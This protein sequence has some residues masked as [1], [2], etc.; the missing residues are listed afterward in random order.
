MAHKLFLVLVW[1]LHTPEHSELGV[2]ERDE[3]GKE[4]EILYHTKG[5]AL[6]LDHT[7]A[8]PSLQDIVTMDRR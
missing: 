2:F 1:E 6:G 5:A 7:A 4:R 8:F 3:G